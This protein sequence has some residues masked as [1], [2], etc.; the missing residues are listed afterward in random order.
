MRPDRDIYEGLLWAECLETAVR[1]LS[2]EELRQVRGSLAR[3]AR[4]EWPATLVEGVCII[5]GCER[6]MN[7][8]E[9][10]EVRG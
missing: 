1:E 8:S 6:F 7:P 5:V 10:K 4:D 3:G 2:D 9:S